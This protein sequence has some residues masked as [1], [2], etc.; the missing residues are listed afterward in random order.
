[1]LARLRSPQRHAAAHAIS[2]RDAR[3]AALAWPVKLL[4]KQGG[5]W[6]A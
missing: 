3:S 6:H 5:K 1:V 4:E 2:L